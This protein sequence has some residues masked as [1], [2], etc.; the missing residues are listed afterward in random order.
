[1][2]GKAG[3]EFDAVPVSNQSQRSASAA[4]RITALGEMTGGIAH[5]FRNILAVIQSGLRLANESIDDPS[6]LRTCLAAAEEGVTR[7]MRLTSRLLAFAKRKDLEPQA[8]SLNDLLKDL[9]MFLK[10]GAGPD[11]RV[12]LDLTPEV[13]KSLVDPPQFN[14][15]ILNLVINARDAMPEGGVIRISTDVVMERETSRSKPTPGVFVCVRVRDNGQGMPPDVLDRIFDPYFTTKGDVGT[16][17]GIPQV[18]AFMKSI[19]GRI[20]VNSN[21]GE[22]TEFE[23]RFP[24]QDWATTTDLRRQIDRWVN[25]GGADEP[26]RT[27]AKEP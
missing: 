11:I 10:Y 24:A 16:G 25:E 21:V 2:D 14:A 8:Q 20:S 7:G 23:L 4:Q 19:G 12:V 13:P 17:L 9:E 26:S 1:M 5:D 18:L 15:A 27:S 6:R 22:G 3:F